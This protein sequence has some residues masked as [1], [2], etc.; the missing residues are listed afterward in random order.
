[1]AQE[2]GE[3]D[4][5]IS[6]AQVV[7]EGLNEALSEKGGDTHIPSLGLIS[8]LRRYHILEAGKP[9]ENA[10][11]SSQNLTLNLTVLRLLGVWLTIC[12]CLG[13]AIKPQREDVMALSC[14]IY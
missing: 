4:S 10:T 13:L 1:M 5:G 14:R 11:P 8:T 2:D 9:V 6:P 12:T 7:E 3:W